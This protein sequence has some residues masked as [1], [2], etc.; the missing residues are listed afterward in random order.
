MEQPQQP[1]VT[2]MKLNGKDLK[3]KPIPWK[4]LKV[5]MKAQQEGDNFAMMEAM[6][7]AIAAC[8]TY[9]DG[10]AIDVDALSAPQITELFTELSGVKEAGPDFTAGSDSQNS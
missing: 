2:K 7:E 9:A 4:L 10:T 1:P 3:L 5:G 8:A 6:V